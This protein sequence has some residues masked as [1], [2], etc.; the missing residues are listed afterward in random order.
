MVYYTRG[1]SHIVVKK[2]ILI[3]LIKILKC[4]FLLI[5][6]FFLYFIS[7]SIVPHMGESI[8][9]SVKYSSF[10]FIFALINYAIFKLILWFIQYYNNIIIVSKDSLVI[11]HCSL[12]L[13]DD[14][15]VVDSYRIVKVDSYSRWFF[16][17]LL[18]Y[19]D[20]IIEQHKNEVR[21][22][23]FIPNPYKF[24]EI[25]KHQRQELLKEKEM[26]ND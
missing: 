17:N 18:G 6:A 2:H 10:F 5:I 4:C 9:W 8:V 12:I 20:I 16:A 1:K 11:L 7:S 26:K 25:M 23:H 24:L 14:V 3:P 15:E 21:T 13:Q 22:F 19:G